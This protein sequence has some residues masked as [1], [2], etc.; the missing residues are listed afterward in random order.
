MKFI[1]AMNIA[2]FMKGIAFYACRPMTQL[3][4]NLF[5]PMFIQRAG[6]VK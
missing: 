1:P 3:S 4:D 5:D 2:K 6:F